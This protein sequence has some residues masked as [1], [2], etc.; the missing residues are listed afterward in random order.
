MPTPIHP[1]GAPTSPN[2]NIAAT[3]LDRFF[4][5]ASMI[6]PHVICFLGT[7]KLSV[8]GLEQFMDE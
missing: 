6:P 3:G 2:Y 5:L 8:L 4:V 7:S 1:Q